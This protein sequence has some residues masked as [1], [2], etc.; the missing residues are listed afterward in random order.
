ME[1]LSV[2]KK[3][4]SPPEDEFPANGDPGEGPCLTKPAREE[5][6]GE[7]GCRDNPDPDGKE[8]VCPPNTETQGKVLSP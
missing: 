1:D 8:R 3:E 2:K 6:N 7:Y 4:K 5:R